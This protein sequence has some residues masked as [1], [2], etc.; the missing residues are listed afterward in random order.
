MDAITQLRKEINIAGTIAQ[1][2]LNYKRG[3]I[4]FDEFILNA[5]DAHSDSI[6][7]SDPSVTGYFREHL[8]TLRDRPD[9]GSN[10]AINTIMDFDGLW[11]VIE[12]ELVCDEEEAD[13][14][15]SAGRRY[16]TQVKGKLVT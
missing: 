10:S 7:N 3:D 11:S 15:W 12:G 1:T 14:I 5:L 4:S 9:E 16:F 13:M 6:I 8:E 2:Y